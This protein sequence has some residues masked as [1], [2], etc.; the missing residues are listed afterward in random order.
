MQ[1]ILSLAYLM[2]WRWNE[3]LTA[4]DLLNREPA[5]I[6]MVAAS[7]DAGCRIADAIKIKKGALTVNMVLSR[8]GREIERQCKAFESFGA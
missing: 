8:I 1:R 3:H 5:P 6:L 2:V 7:A 4:S